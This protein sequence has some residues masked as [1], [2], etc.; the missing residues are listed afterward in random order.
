MRRLALSCAC[1]LAVLGGALSAPGASAAT[2]CWQAVIA[3][4][5]RDN[6][7]DGRY[8]PECLRQAMVNAP[9]D[10][11]IYSSV[12]ED[13]RAALQT[14]SAR[15]LSGA[16]SATAASV[17]TPGGSSP[18]SPLVLTL[19]GI[20]ALAALLAAVAIVRRRRADV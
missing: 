14:R 12:E 17:A 20:A 19:G 18:L 10:L 3:D 8:S 7:V 16:H 13:L 1:A 5:S 6:A 9:T 15:R 4:W 2:P 11:K